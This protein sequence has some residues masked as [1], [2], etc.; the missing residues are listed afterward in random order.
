MLAPNIGLSNG[1]DTADISRYG[2]FQ[3][4]TTFGETIMTGKVK[5]NLI[6]V[7][8]FL[9]LAGVGCGP[10]AFLI[11]AVPGGR[12]LKETVIEKDKGFFV[13]DKIAVIDVDGI[14]INS[15]GGLFRSKDNQVSLFVE[16]LDKARKDSAVKAIV[17][18]LNS[19][20]GTIGAS[21]TMYHQLKLFKEKCKKPVV[22]CM[23]DVAASG[24]YYL[25]CGA[26]GI[27]A[28]P[29][30]ITGSIGTI[31]QTIN[32][33]GTMR[34]LGVRTETIK[35]G[36]LKDIGSPYREMTEEERELFAGLINEF[37][38]QFLNVVDQGRPSLTL[39]HIRKLADGR[40]F[41]AKEALA[42]G[43]IDKIG[44]PSQAVEWAKKLASIE[45]AHVVMYHRPAGY[46]PN[47]YSSA[48]YNK[49]TTGALI[50]L[51]LP[52][53]LNSNGTHFLY[54]WQPGSE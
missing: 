3:Y 27:M 32:V 12:K 23:L 42:N 13:K 28:Q 48:N 8:L 53:W 11:Q 38:E 34:M 24:A 17:L 30:T 18:R 45:K 14:M 16:K 26:D 33:A 41:A 21:D 39:E 19:P 31:I 36:K 9:L 1:C 29:S 47:I 43:L 7:I 51:D 25:A 46:K 40:V 22:A 44:Y 5:K 54:L 50:N 49:T 20:G 37:Y 35:S 15:R 4:L 6:V 10:T 52:D 2:E